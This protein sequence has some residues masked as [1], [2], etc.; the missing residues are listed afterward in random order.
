MKMQK[1]KYQKP[2]LEIIEMEPDE[3]IAA[4]LVIYYSSHTYTGCNEVQ[5]QDHDPDQCIF[6][7]DSAAS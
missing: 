2:K 7:Q 6:Y 1:K 3:K 4:C 5:F